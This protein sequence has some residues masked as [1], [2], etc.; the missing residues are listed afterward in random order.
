MIIKLNPTEEDVVGRK[1]GVHKGSVKD[2]TNISE[3]N[4][5]KLFLLIH[6]LNYYI[7][8][9]HRETYLKRM[10]DHDFISD[11]YALEYLKNQTTKFGVFLKKPNYYTPLGTSI[12]YETWYNFYE[13]YFFE[14]L[15]T[16]QFD[17]F[18]QDLN[19]GKDVTKYLPK[20]NWKQLVYK[21]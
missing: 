12:Y 1:Y 16:D 20:K 13:N 14:E 18:E 11:I 10:K 5:I 17:K 21:R 19:A 8:R 4:E 3:L 15:T 7:W 6:K 9:C 2:I